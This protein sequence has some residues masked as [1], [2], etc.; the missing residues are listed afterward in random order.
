VPECGPE[1]SV[2]GAR[3]MEIQQDGMRSKRPHELQRRLCGGHRTRI[4]SEVLKQLREHLGAFGVVFN[5]AY[6]ITMK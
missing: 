2:V 6:E 5:E 1:A 3:D 4:G